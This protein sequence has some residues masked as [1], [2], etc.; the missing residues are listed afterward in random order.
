MHFLRV[1]AM[2]VWAAFLTVSAIT[3]R[4]QTSTI[5]LINGSSYKQSHFSANKIA[6]T[7]KISPDSSL[8]VDNPIY[9]DNGIYSEN[10]SELIL[11]GTLDA[12]LTY[13]IRLNGDAIARSLFDSPFYT[14]VFVAGSNNR[15]EGRPQFLTP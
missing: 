4:D 5:Q 11:T 6:G 15:I 14:R 12:S 1:V 3:F 10:G 2:A 8:T 9:F 7:F 13:S